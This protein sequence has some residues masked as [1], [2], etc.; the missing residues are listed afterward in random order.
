[1]HIYNKAYFLEL[2][3]NLCSFHSL[4]FAAAPII[5]LF[6]TGASFETLLSIANLD[7]GDIVKLIRKTIDLLYQI[8]NADFL[9]LIPKQTLNTCVS[10]LNRDIVNAV[11]NLN[12]TYFNLNLE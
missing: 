8:K 3:Y 2:K 4:S 10:L 12:A 7:E 1:M 6:S 5:Y 11:E 9:N